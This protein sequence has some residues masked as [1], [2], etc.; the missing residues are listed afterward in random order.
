MDK[1]IDSFKLII[2]Q[3][4]SRFKLK[5]LHLIDIILNY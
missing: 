5:Y 2:P 1:S 4:Y 3:T